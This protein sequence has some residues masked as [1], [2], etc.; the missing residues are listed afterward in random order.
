M[1][2]HIQC[3]T[4]EVY[5]PDLPAAH[6][7]QQ[8]VSRWLSSPAFLGQLSEKLDL[9]VP[10]EMVVS[11]SRLAIDIEATD[12]FDF[13]QKLIYALVEAVGQW[14]QKNP[15]AA[16]PK[17]AYWHELMIFYVEN[18]FLP[19]HTS[20][21]TKQAI[22]RLLHTLPTDWATDEWQEVLQK[23]RRQP[24]ILQRLTGHI[25]WQK[26]RLVLI[27]HLKISPKAIQWIEEFS[28][29]LLLL[30]SKN[31]STQRTEIALWQWLLSTPPYSHQQADHDSFSQYLAKIAVTLPL[32][33]KPSVASVAAP[34]AHDNPAAAGI[35]IQNAGLVLLAPF[36][37]Q[38]F[39][40]LGWTEGNDWKDTPSQHQAIRLLAYLSHDSIE[41]YEYDWPLNKLLCGLPIEDAL[42]DEQ[43]LDSSTRSLADELLQMV[44]K[45]WSV[46]KTMSLTRFR[47]VFLQREGKLSPQ[48]DGNGW[49]LQIARQTEDILLERLPWSVSVIKLPWMPHI[50]FVEW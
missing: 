10:E 4:V 23:A 22:E 17:Q 36:L 33:S 45:E 46:L 1:T 6:H 28:E 7:R 39:R 14:Q 9:L 15:S 29:N 43:T 41:T 50:L 25:G 11:I 34:D 12:E 13:Q 24:L 8:E 27:N 37:S 20:Y 47:E 38:L 31:Y 18:G 30:W 42:F 19:P 26:M 49:Q 44:I 5:A 16:L 21:D 32:A 48:P 3:L 40:A 2:H 35:F